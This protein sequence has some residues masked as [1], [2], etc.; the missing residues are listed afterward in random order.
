MVL[1][2]ADFVPGV[3]IGPGLLMPHPNGVVFGNGFVVGSNVTFGAGVTAGVRQ[4][5]D[6]GGFPVVGDGAI[7]LTHVVLAGPIRVGM[8]AQVG[9]NSVV[10][11]DVAD[12][13]VVVGSPARQVGT[14]EVQL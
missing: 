1:V 10:L 14:R 7:V 6:P 3:N 8:H 13:A 11:S 9:A 5:D 2:S 12:Y 4:P